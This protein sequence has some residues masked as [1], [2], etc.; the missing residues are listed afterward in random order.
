MAKAKTPTTENI[1]E[2]LAAAIQMVLS[3]S[4]VV[5][6]SVSRVMLGTTHATNAV[7]QRRDLASVAVI[8]NRRPRHKIGAA[9]VHMA[10]RSSQ[11]RVSRRDH[12]G[13]CFEFD[14]R[15]HVPFDEPDLRRF[16]EDLPERPE[17]CAITST[18]SP[19]SAEHEHIAAAVVADVFG[20]DTPVSLS[21]DI[22][23]IGILERE[24]ACVLNAAL[25]RVARQIADG[26]ST[27]L[28]G[29]G[30]RGHAVLRSER[31]DAD[32]RSRGCLSFRC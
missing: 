4:G 22:G 11:S 14:G 20:Q 5:P 25:R 7:L 19:V 10:S 32:G 8:P 21:C 31:R 2:G 17:A 29:T 15:E 28:R 1:D 6:A 13:R 16:L 3:A 9:A 24:N 18:F 12:R 26:L 27:V 23:S 30:H